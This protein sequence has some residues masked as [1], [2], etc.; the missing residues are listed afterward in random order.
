MTI[1]A[2]AEKW[3]QL[4]AEAER[5]AELRK[6]LEADQAA[7]KKATAEKAKLAEA[8]RLAELRKQL[9][10]DQAA[11]KKATAEKARLENRKKV[12]AERAAARKAQAE[13]LAAKK[14]EEEKQNELEADRLAEEEALIAQ[15]QS[16]KEDAVVDHAPQ[17]V[18]GDAKS[19]D[20]GGI[21]PS[22]DS[23]DASNPK[24]SKTGNIG[25][26]ADRQRE[27]DRLFQ[28]VE[29]V[30]GKA[31]QEKQI[32]KVEIGS[33]DTSADDSGSEVEEPTS[34][35]DGVI[36][37]I[38]GGKEN[39]LDE[40]YAK[41]VKEDAVGDKD[42]SDSK[43]KPAPK[44]VKSNGKMPTIKSNGNVKV[45]SNDIVEESSNSQKATAANVTAVGNGFTLLDSIK[46][47]MF[48]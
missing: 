13:R 35:V 38:S 25:G 22:V 3:K 29:E 42:D 43:G 17:T 40:A 21:Q 2:A 10:A 48:K 36:A 15:F 47:S 26:K 33:S 12:E 11:V 34:K 4:E 44:V 20:P 7:V 19:V 39:D 41:R 14:A 16:Q 24:G 30:L 37:D 28:A 9:E 5:L 31:K 23:I 27:K 18:S 45:S 1:K 6:Q 8:E 32:N 46:K